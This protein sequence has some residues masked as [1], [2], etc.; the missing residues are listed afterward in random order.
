MSATKAEK[1]DYWAH[2]I[3]R[4]SASGKTQQNYCDQHQLKLHQLLYW[5][6]VLRDRSETDSN[7]GTASGFVAVQLTQSA[8]PPTQHLIIELPNGL[9][10]KEVHAGNLD[11]VQAIS[12]WQP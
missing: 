6:R 5:R 8:E 11:V 2:H 7:G 4:W 12:R 9:R 3:K 10:I 1:R